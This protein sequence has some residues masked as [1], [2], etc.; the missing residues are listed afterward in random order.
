MFKSRFFIALLGIY[1]LPF[2]GF[3]QSKKNTPPPNWY[4]LD[5]QTDG[6]M[7]ISTEKAYELLKGLSSTPVTVAVIDGGVDV[8]HE[9]LSDVLWI[10]TSDS[11]ANGAD[12]DGNGYINDKYGWNFIGN[13]NGENIDH[14]NLE[15]TRLIAQYEPKYISVLPS[16]RLSEAERRE[17]V[18]YQ[19]MV[20]DYTTK[21]DQA[22]FGDLHYSRLKQSVDNMIATIGKE[23]KDI[24]KA[25]LDK[26]TPADDRQKT[27]L[28]LAK[29]DTEKES[30]A[31]FYEDLEDAAD[32]YNAQV[33]YHLNKKFDPRHIVGDN[34]EDSSERY[35][36]NND[37]KGPD[38][39]HGT[40][41]A[42]IIGANR[43]NDIGV[44]G[45]ADNV[46]IMSI[47]VVPNGD[48]RDKD[49]ANGIRYAV[50][51]GAKIINM[52]FGKGYVYDKKTVDE[53]VRYAVEKDVLLVH[54]AGNDGKN[55]DI[56]PNYP[57][58]Y[59]TDSLH[60]VTGEANA[61]ITVGATKWEVNGDLLAD[62][63]NYGYKSVDVFAPGVSI[64]S[65]MP[66]NK[67]KAQQ[68]TSMAA[69]VVS[70]LAAILRSYY[71]QLTAKEVKDIILKSV[72]K[73]DQKVR[74]RQEGSSKRV[75]LDEISVS[76]GIVN[77]YNAI[78]EANNYLATKK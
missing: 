20:S 42:G 12:N 2:S 22:Q 60:A 6:V 19:R 32:Y 52:S 64:N 66:D 53:A 67:Y 13:A 76:G 61:W 36:G 25:D 45:V 59:F 68:G 71:P 63:S 50:D 33:K 18:A 10:N 39:D 3:A 74:V 40:H 4:N 78:K 44:N 26:Y 16:T 46:K 37:V 48:E 70:G 51:N 62:F 8:W 35:Y 23:P 30:F 41:V 24:T 15:V 43:K 77:A 73:V 5:Y 21:M 28:Q 47:R 75:Y 27:A 31:K 29:K 55:I 65:T 7:G 1:I 72:A 34:Y 17:F 58:K 69:P 14:D 54:A 56:N 57:T 9:D 38:A 11:I 49:V